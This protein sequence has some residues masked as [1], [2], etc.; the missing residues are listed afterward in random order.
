MKKRALSFLCD[1]RTEKF[2]VLGKNTFSITCEVSNESNYSKEISNKIKNDLGVEAKNIFDLS[3]GSTFQEDGE[4]VKEMIF[5]SF[6][7][8]ESISKKLILV[9]LNDFIK[10]I[11]WNDEK[12]LLKK[13][14]FKALNQEAYFDK[15]ERGQ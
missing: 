9:T 12:K 15:K 10:D 11:K 7:D 1:I 4:E 5:L 6:L 14:L 8:A 13:V 2:I 3:W